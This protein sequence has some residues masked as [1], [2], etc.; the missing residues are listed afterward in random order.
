AGK[1][2]G[3]TAGGYTVGLLNAVTGRATAR[4]EDASGVRGTQEVEPLAD[5]FV[6][7]LKRDMRGG[8]MVVGG[9][10]SGVV[11]GIDSTFAPRLARHAEMYGNDLVL[12]SVD[13]KY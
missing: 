12:T 8:N 3:R 13:K 5:Y 11:R 1:L 6:T 4:V 2:T 7:R 9:V 10:V